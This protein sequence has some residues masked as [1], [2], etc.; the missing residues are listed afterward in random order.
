MRPRPIYDH[1]R[2]R[3][4]APRCA[5]LHGRWGRPRRCGD[6]DTAGGAVLTP[7]ATALA[8]LVRAGEVTPRE[9]VAAAID[10]IETVNPSINALIS[11][12]FERALD[13]A[14][15]PGVAS[16]RFGGVPI[17]LKDH[18]SGSAGDP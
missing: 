9:L 2:A 11:T 16:T 3:L 4:P 7:D 14:A 10:R 18:L 8:S 12:R 5:D 1:R 17:V 15:A 13:E 6:V